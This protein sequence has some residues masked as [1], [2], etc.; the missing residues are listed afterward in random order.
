[1]ESNSIH[2][3]IVDDE[4]DARDLMA[5]IIGGFRELR[6]L[7]TA[8]NAF[9][10]LQL[11]SRLKPDIAFVDINMPLQSGLE[12]A[13]LVAQSQR[14]TSIVFVTAYDAYVMQ[15]IRSSA[16]DYLLKPVDPDELTSMIERYKARKELLLPINDTPSANKIRLNIRTG[17]ILVDPGE[18][19]MISAHGNYAEIH[20]CNKEKFIVSQAIGCISGMLPA[21]QFLRVSRSALINLKYLRQVDRKNRTAILKAGDQE[22]QACIS[23]EHMADLDELTQ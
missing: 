8:C 9:E 16:F 23:R 2:V 10:G 3:V 6:L 13:E 21:G 17:Y 5:Q 12:L 15:A 20:L 1:M 7:G 14:H 19:V 22:L 11:I 4:P 18:I